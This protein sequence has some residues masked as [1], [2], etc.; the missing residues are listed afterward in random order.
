MTLRRL[1]ASKVEMGPLAFGTAYLVGGFEKNKSRR[2]VHAAF[3][4]GFRHFDVAPIYGLGTAEE[5]LGDALRGRREQVTIATK[6]GLE[7]HRASPGTLLAHAL[8][9][10]VKPYLPPRSAS[11]PG[12]PPVGRFD[13]PFVAAALA[14]SLKKLGTDR[15]DLYL[16]HEV[17]P[18][19]VSDELLAFLDK[20]RAEGRVRALGVASSLEASLEIERKYPGLF[21]VH[22]FGW[23]VVDA[24]LNAKPGGF[25][26]THGAILRALE[27]VQRLLTQDSDIVKRV[28]EECGVDASQ[29]HELVKLLVAAAVDRNKDGLVI[30]ASR[31]EGRT[32]QFS[33]AADPQLGAKA[34]RF[35][36]LIQDAQNR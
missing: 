29:Q 34:E 14:S 21:D 33:E 23:S 4:A 16:L 13:V 24:P 35:A 30:V 25:T 28:R 8:Y 15:V 26:I 7:G 2:L 11:A 9:Q 5:T 6:V 22:Q 3:D 36:R 12:V 17:R 32:R 27:R 10:P 1:P 20:A 18:E 19:Q 31:K